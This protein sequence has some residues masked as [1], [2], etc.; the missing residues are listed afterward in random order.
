[1]RGVALRR[2]AAPVAAASTS[3]NVLET[4]DLSVSYGPVR[5]LRGVSIRVA[6]GEMVALLGANGAGKS[7][8]L[9][10]IS[11]MVAP[12]SGSIR[13]DGAEI[14]GLPAYRVV[15][16]GLAHLPEGRELFPTLT[17]E[18][19]L[20]FGYYPKR[21]ERSRYPEVLD[22]VMDVFPKLRE[23]RRQAAG[24]LS[25]GEQQML[26]A[27]RAMM[28]SPRVLLIDELSLGL[29][30][31][32]VGDLFDALHQVNAAGTAVLIVEQFIHL[33]LRHT[34]RAYVL[35]KGEVVLEGP[36]ARLERDPDVVAAY[37][38]SGP[39]EAAPSAPAPPR[40]RRAVADRV[41]PLMRS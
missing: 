41:D 7:T 32:I 14:A 37:L 4:E 26:A 27:A 20:R 36:S 1:M 8:T 9:R 25:G 11:G 35:A 3:P 21:R 40:R 30:P 28:S 19:N 12:E 13:L 31:K 2:Q 5:A 29:A 24:T 10:A 23:R 15:G 22:H 34:N 33:A 17:I 39:T 38:G 16:R 6:P 18:E